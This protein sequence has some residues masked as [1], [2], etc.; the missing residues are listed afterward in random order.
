LDA[1]MYN[2]AVVEESKVNP[3]PVNVYAASKV[4]SEKFTWDYIARHKP[5][6]VVTSIN[7]NVVLGAPVPRYTLSGTGAMLRDLVN[8]KRD[9]MLLSFGPTN[10]V[11]VDDVSRLHILALIREDVKAERIL[12]CG[13][14]Y[15]INQMIEV[16]RKVKPDSPIESKDE[17]NVEDNTIVDVARANELLKDQG[18]LHDLEYSVRRLIESQTSV[19]G[20]T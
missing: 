15:T 7:P 17:W 6:F 8:G 2:D 3:N 14:G 11:D 10:P 19:I 1:S 13:N 16:I 9:V 12:A 5:S 20:S 4:L 18:G